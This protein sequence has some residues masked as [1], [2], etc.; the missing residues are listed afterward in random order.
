M[1]AFAVTIKWCS[2]SPQELGSSSRLSPEEGHLLPKMWAEVAEV[3]L[4]RWK[5][6]R[7]ACL[8]LLVARL[9]GTVRTGS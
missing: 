1:R 4:R 3:A 6:M 9:G 5:P 2:A 8:V 7:A